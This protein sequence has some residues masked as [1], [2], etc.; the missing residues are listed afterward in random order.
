MCQKY[1]HHLYGVPSPEENIQDEDHAKAVGMVCPRMGSEAS[2]GR[3]S[4]SSQCS[5]Q[6]ETSSKLGVETPWPP[7]ERPNVFHPPH[8]TYAPPMVTAAVVSLSVVGAV[9]SKQ[10]ALSPG[11]CPPPPIIFSPPLCQTYGAAGDQILYPAAAGY[12]AASGAP[13]TG[14][15]FVGAFADKPG[16]GLIHSPSLSVNQPKSRARSPL[17]TPGPHHPAYPAEPFQNMSTI[18]FLFTRSPSGGGNVA[19]VGPPFHNQPDALA[20]YR[21][22]LSRENLAPNVPSVFEQTSNSA[23]QSGTQLSCPGS[24]CSSRSGSLVGEDV[25]YIQGK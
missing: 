15:A 12:Q 17:P 21:L 16:Y 11:N 3:S 9:T 2:S 18:P 6:L 8:A 25:T 1:Q 19:S 4:S 24:G 22:S 7:Q 20:G 23:C 5:G 10:S 13:V 14:E